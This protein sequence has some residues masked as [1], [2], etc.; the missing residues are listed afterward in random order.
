MYLFL[1]TPADRWEAGVEFWAAVT[2]SRVS[3]PRGETGQFI[4]LVPSEGSAW[5]KMQS[6]PE[7]PARVH[8]DLDDDLDPQEAARHSESLGA[9]AGWAYPDV[10]VMRSPGGLLFCHTTGEPGVRPRLARN[11]RSI[12]DQV[13]LDIP[14]RLWAAEVSFWQQLTGRPLE[15]GSLP[16][17][18]FL[19]DPDPAGPPRMLLQR[20]DD[21]A[22][23]VTAHVDF[24]TSE[25]A[26]E[27]RRHE[28]LG[29]RVI[30]VEA[31]WTVLSAPSGHVYCLT[32]RDPA[33]GRV[34]AGRR[35]G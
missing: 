27:T 4:T 17:F 18:A 8:I 6:L 2:E 32:D 24:A 15:P 33:T 16:E 14:P 21:E 9:S 35:S 1:D 19:G 26:D 3:E 13:C 22:P 10:A 29:A 20:L 12:V 28:E 11:S 23:A 31:W 7:G 30:R 34:P 5:L 25:R